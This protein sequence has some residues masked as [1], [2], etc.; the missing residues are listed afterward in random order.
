MSISEVE[1]TKLGIPQS[2]ISDEFPQT[3]HGQLADKLF[4]K[5]KEKERQVHS[6]RSFGV[7]P[8]PLDFPTETAGFVG[9]AHNS[10]FNLSLVYG[11]TPPYIFD[12]QEDFDRFSQ[13]GL[14]SL[15]DEQARLALTVLN[16]EDGGKEA[17]RT[18]SQYTQEKREQAVAEG[19]LPTY[20]MWFLE[21][22]DQYQRMHSWMQTEAVYYA[23][24]GKQVDLA[25][26]HI[27]DI[28]KRKSRFVAEARLVRRMHQMLSNL[29]DEDKVKVTILRMPTEVSNTRPPRALTYFPARTFGRWASSEDQSNEEPGEFYCITD[30][31]CIHHSFDTLYRLT[32]IEKPNGQFEARAFYV[33]SQRAENHEQIADFPPSGRR[34]LEVSFADGKP[35]IPSIRTD[36]GEKFPGVSFKTNHTVLKEDIEPYLVFDANALH[37]VLGE[38]E[39]GQ[40]VTQDLIP[41]VVD[42]LIGGVGNAYNIP[43]HQFFT[44]NS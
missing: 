12:S 38:D 41:Y 36:V 13:N 10:L 27:Q 31:A 37:F 19:D 22:V 8:Q 2:A 16:A 32:R 15:T 23:A 7:E 14:T 17:F 24:T 5:I 20:L 39:Y 30:A 40:K 42:S 1:Y 43:V 3:I 35:P 4:G 26:S 28:E 18:L 34:F 6:I 44:K 25:A 33:T 29:P 9:E 21:G 11:I